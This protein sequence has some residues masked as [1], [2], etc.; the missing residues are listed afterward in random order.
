[1]R[2]VL[3]PNVLISSLLSPSGPPGE[4]LRRWTGGE[5]ELVVSKAVLAELGRALAYPKLRSRVSIDDASAFIQLLERTA[6]MVDDPVDVPR[7]SR[8]PGGDFL[9]ALAES[10]SAILVTGDED[11]LNLKQLPVQ[12]AREFL[13]HLRAR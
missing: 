4:I 1:L 2:V 9:L 13:V 6:T 3:D 7:R 5:F 12:S 8:D 11:L 10:W